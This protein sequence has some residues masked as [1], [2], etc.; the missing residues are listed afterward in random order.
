MARVQ[1]T[2]I[3][4]PGQRIAPSADFKFD[5]LATL[6]AQ[7]VPTG[8]DLIVVYPEAWPDLQVTLLGTASTRLNRVENLVIT[9]VT[10]Q[11]DL[12]VIGPITRDGYIQPDGMIYLDSDRSAKMAL[13]NG[14]IR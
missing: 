13:F 5:W 10:G 4:F 2:P 6:E 11:S 7:W 1:L 14:N 12:L 8:A 9:W 3:N